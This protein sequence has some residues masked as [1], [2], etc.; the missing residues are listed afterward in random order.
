MTLGEVLDRVEYHN[1]ALYAE[2]K[3]GDGVGDVCRI[4]YHAAQKNPKPMLYITMCGAPV[5]EIPANLNWGLYVV[6]KTEKSN[7]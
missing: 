1:G 6:D 5:S 4:M 7:G 2:A 3:I